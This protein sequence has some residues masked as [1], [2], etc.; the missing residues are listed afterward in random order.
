MEQGLTTT[1]GA[2]E[3]AR[4]ESADEESGTES[5]S[6]TFLD[7]HAR[8]HCVLGYP[9]VIQLHKAEDDSVFKETTKSHQQL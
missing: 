2:A 6:D 1:G 3:E 8:E 5:E 9:F 4:A 7:A